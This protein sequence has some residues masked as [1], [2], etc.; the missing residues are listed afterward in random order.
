MDKLDRNLSISSVELEKIPFA[1]HQIVDEGVE[2]DCVRKL[3]RYR[4]EVYILGEKL[5]NYS[6]HIEY[7]DGWWQSL[8][9]SLYARMWFPFWFLRKFP[10]RNK[11]FNLYIDVVALY[12]ELSARISLPEENHRLI[13]QKFEN[14]E[15]CQVSL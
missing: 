2:Y 12:P 14:E 11:V 10:V 1:V 7:P 8:K 13:L 6:R 15:V 4:L 5:K 9:S 3:S